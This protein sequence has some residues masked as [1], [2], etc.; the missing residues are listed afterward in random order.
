MKYA[1]GVKARIE[2]SEDSDIEINENA[3]LGREQIEIQIS[4]INTKLITAGS[5]VRAKKKAY[6]ASK[7]AMPFDLK[8]VDQAEYELALA[9]KKQKELKEDKKNRE[10][11]LKELF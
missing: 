11:L 1:E 2:K 6:E 10:A 7:F 9:E 4:Q 8:E 5:E 3:E